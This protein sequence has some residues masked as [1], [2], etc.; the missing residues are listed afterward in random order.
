[1][2]DGIGKQTAD[3]IGNWS[4]NQTGDGVKNGT[5]QELQAGWESCQQ[6]EES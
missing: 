4:R 5:V 3:E 2:A 6:W 1:M